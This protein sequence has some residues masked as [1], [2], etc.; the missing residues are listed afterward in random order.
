[1][2]F[3]VCK[4][5]SRPRCTDLFWLHSHVRRRA[6]TIPCSCVF[7][8]ER[9][10][11]TRATSDPCGGART[12]AYRHLLVFADDQYAHG[13]FRNWVKLTLHAQDGLGRADEGAT[14]GT[15]GGGGGPGR[16]VDRDLIRWAFSRLDSTNRF[17]DRPA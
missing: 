17:P 8:L 2:T 5:L 13:I 14:A 16:T 6:P 9:D 3:C 10:R 12:S 15:P 4:H 11:T 7:S 1:V